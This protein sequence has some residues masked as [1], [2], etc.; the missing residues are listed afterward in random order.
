MTTKIT[1]GNINMLAAK[2]RGSK[3][4]EV[5]YEGGEIN[6]SLKDVHGLSIGVATFNEEEIK[7]YFEV[8]DK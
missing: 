1:T 2:I 8:E 6:L 7:H 3:I 5:W 4:D